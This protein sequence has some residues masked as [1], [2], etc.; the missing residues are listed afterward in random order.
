MTI[1]RLV[2]RSVVPLS[3]F[4]ALALVTQACG[5]SQEQSVCEQ[6]CDCEGC[7]E[8]DF[9]DCV[10]VLEDLK[11]DTES[12]GCA[13]DYQD[14]LSCLDKDLECDDDNEVD[15][16]ECADE[17]EEVSDC[18]DDDVLGVA[19]TESGGG[20]DDDPNDPPTGGTACDEI[21]ACCIA[22]AEQAM[23]ST[24]SC[25]GYDATTE[26]ACQAAIDAYVT[27]PDTEVP[28]ECQFQ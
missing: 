11:Q 19:H 16:D 5:S 4:G 26:A 23:V 8:G 9:N 17:L 12:E 25:A 15:L 24:A 6:A 7:D 22:A 18:L 10:D 20:D 2:L 27:P 13:N 28:P 1:R 21:K 14:L 3:L